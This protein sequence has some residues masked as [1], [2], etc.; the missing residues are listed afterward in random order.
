MIF[1][2]PPTSS[3]VKG[4]IKDTSVEPE[5]QKSAARPCFRARSHFRRPGSGTGAAA[6]APAPP[7]LPSGGGRIGD[8]RR[9][10]APVPGEHLGQWKVSG[11]GGGCQSAGWLTPGGGGGGMRSGK[12]VWYCRV[13]SELASR[14]LAIR[15][16][17]LAAYS[18]SFWG[19]KRMKAKTRS[20]ISVS[21][22]M[23]I[24]LPEN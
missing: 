11:V 15:A 3:L 21:K 13:R 16:P 17:S 6:R 1:R 14:S 20:K 18:G 9:N 5:R 23:P 10:P 8:N 24:S 2:A 7:L 19:P 12:E 4:L 22:S